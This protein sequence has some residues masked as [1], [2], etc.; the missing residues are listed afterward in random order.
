MKRSAKKFLSALIASVTAFTSISCAPAL[1]NENSSQEA[2]STY[3][4]TTIQTDVIT[5]DTIIVQPVSPDAVSYNRHNVIDYDTY[6]GK[7]FNVNIDLTNV[8]NTPGINNYTFFVT[9]DPSVVRMT[10]LIE[11]DASM[12]D[13][14]VTY[15]IIIG[16][17]QIDSPLNSSAKTVSKSIALVPGESKYNYADYADVLTS[18][19]SL[20]TCG[21]LGKVKFSNC[22][23]TPNSEDNLSVATKSGTL[24]TLSF[25]VIGYGDTKIAVDL[26]YPTVSGLCS[27]PKESTALKSAAVDGK[28]FVGNAPEVSTETSTETTTETT[29]EP[30]TAPGTAGDVNLDGRISAD[31]A[32][33]TLQE[34]LNNAFEMPCE[35]YYPDTYMLIA[36]V[37][38]D[39][40]ITSSDSSYI[41]QKT[42]NNA[43]KLPIEEIRGE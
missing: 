10:G 15:P 7:E 31:D 43:F 11:P 1:A 9:Y 24:M 37:N 17:S 39:N 26:T 25:E 2:D 40:L 36:D 19:T 16:S 5:D 27:A 4:K 38:A 6:I 20:L 32:A 41:L 18:D 29:T 13:N 35:L 23:K 3:A 30:T 22:I 12:L 14:F 34:T 8:E 42:L 28:I 33:I 21:E